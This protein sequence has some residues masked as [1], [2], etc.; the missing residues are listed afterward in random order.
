MN[1]SKFWAFITFCRET[2]SKEL[3][4]SLVLSGYTVGPL[5]PENPSL[6]GDDSPSLVLA[7]S[8]SCEMEANADDIREHVVN[9]SEY[10]SFKY[11]SIVI[12]R[13][14]TDATA[15]WNQS[16]VSLSEVQNAK[17]QKRLKAS[18]LRLV[19]PLSEVESIKPEEVPEV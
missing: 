2:D 8:I 4:S 18:H 16:N 7:I 12:L 10:L 14:N 6:G 17:R 11:Y 19:P 1:E 9:I 13:P 3:I 5:D 15:S